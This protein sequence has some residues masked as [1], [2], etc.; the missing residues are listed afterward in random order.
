MIRKKEAGVEWLEFELL[1]GFPQVIHGV[2]LK[3]GGQSKGPFASLN[4]ADVGDV[5]S[6]VQANFKKVQSITGLSHIIYARC[7]HGVQIEYIS[8]KETATSKWCDGFI[9]SEPEIGLMISH[10]D[11]QAGIFFDPKEKRIACIHAGWRGE[12]QNIYGHAIEKMRALGSQPSD[13]LVCISPSLGPSFS[14]FVNYKK[15]FPEELWDFQFKPTYFNLWDMAYHQLLTQGIHPN[16][17][18]IARICTYQQKEDFFS[19]RRDK[20]T[21]RNGTVVGLKK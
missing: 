8:K 5:L 1:Q 15:E 14:E 6:D 13:L 17:I 11:C 3:H 21:G 9:T 10:A 2:F 7:I 4:I 19:Y 16:H 18:E 12:V 20:I